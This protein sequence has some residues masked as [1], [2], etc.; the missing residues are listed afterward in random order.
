MVDYTAFWCGPI[1]QGVHAWTQ[2]HGLEY[3]A[4][5]GHCFSDMASSVGLGAVTELQVE[6]FRAR[7]HPDHDCVIDILEPD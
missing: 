3:D 1:P 6:A 2:T 5:D 4:G 7:F